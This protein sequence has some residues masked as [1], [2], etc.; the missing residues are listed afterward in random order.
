MRP[1][2]GLHVRM[3]RNLYNVV[4]DTY[5]IPENHSDRKNWI[6]ALAHVQ[7]RILTF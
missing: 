7:V 5:E 2:V 1:H 3:L 4:I 6:S